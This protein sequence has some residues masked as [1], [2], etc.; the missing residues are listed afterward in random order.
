MRGCYIIC[1][2]IMLLTACQSD[3]VFESYQE[4]PGERWDY[5][6][7][8]EF[9][10]RIPDSGLY[11]VTLHIR[12][13][14]SFEM[15]NLWCIVNTRSQ[16]V[17]QL[18]D[19]VNINIATPSGDWFGEGGQIKTVSQTINKNPVA[20]PKGKVLFRIEQGMKPEN[21]RGVK[22]VGIRIEKIKDN[23]QSR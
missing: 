7:V 3:V 21:L 4:L 16:A 13:T 10:A 2:L 22:N 15:T 8:L 11:R 5:S 9:N 1:L 23:I 18:H 14:G 6:R 19:T 20:L 12:H 17:Q